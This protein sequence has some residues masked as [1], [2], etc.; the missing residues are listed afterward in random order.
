MKNL[1]GYTID[2]I[3]CDELLNYD[4]A[5]SQIAKSLDILAEKVSKFK[6]TEIQNQYFLQSQPKI[7]KI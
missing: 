1:N 4:F 3:I 6:S 5:N 7:K 2:S